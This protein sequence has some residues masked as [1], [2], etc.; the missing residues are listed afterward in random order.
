MTG[1]GTPGLPPPR[2]AVD[3]LGHA[4][5]ERALLQA[6]R[7]DRLPGAWLFGGPSGVGKATLAFRFAR[8]VLAGGGA[9]GGATVADDDRDGTE[10]ALYLA[11]DH[12]V[13]RRVAAGGHADLL[14]LERPFVNDQGRETRDLNVSMA[15]RIAPFLR[16][17]PAEGGWRFVIIDEAHTMTVNAANAILKILEEPPP[18]ALIVLI[19]DKPGALLPTIRSRCRQLDIGPLPEPVVL[20]AL[21]RAAPDA[22]DGD[23]KIA[24]RL[25]DGSLGRAIAVLEGDGP[26][27]CREIVDLLGTLP[28]LDPVA[29]HD[30]ADRLSPAA[31][32]PAYRLATGLLVWWLGRL[33][34]SLARGALPPEIVPGETRIM[35]RLAGLGGLDR[36]LAVWDNTA[37]LFAQ[38]D[39][40]NLDRKHVVLHALMNIKA[41]ADS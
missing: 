12:P 15:R 11:P 10:G 18:R 7:A 3:L 1:P 6:V 30:M 24:A 31:A 41:A 28:K 29:A 5:A 39:S 32:E 21:A 4:D 34:R 13:F 36:W 9:A 19:S 35:R 38:A 25:A 20:D 27:L 2:E 40:A 17:T 8:F 16:L 33:V 22:D 37:R 14:V 26:G 23:R